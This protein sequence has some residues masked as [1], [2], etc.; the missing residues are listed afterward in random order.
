MA[1]AALP[2]M[3][4]CLPK[5]SLSLFCLAAEMHC[6]PESQQY[7]THTVT[8]PQVA[9]HGEALIVEL[10]SLVQIAGV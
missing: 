8:V 3:C 2:K 1:A 6:Y 9:H 10:G 7:G 4:L 5:E